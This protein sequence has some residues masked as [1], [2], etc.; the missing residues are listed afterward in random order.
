MS[1]ACLSAMCT[2]DDDIPL[3]SSS[4]I[5]WQDYDTYT[6]NSAMC[7]NPVIFNALA[8]DVC[9]PDTA[10]TSFKYKYPN[11]LSYMTPDCSGTAIK[12]AFSAISCQPFTNADG[13]IAKATTPSLFSAGSIEKYMSSRDALILNHAKNVVEKKERS[14]QTGDDDY[15]TPG[16]AS[17]LTYISSSS[18][19][20][21]KLSKG[22]VAGIIAGIIVFIILVVLALRLTG[23]IGD[24]PNISSRTESTAGSKDSGAVELRETTTS[25]NPMYNNKV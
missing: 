7:Y 15:V 2:N 16:V 17:S 3:P 6:Y 24:K 4:Y 13:T 20:S 8:N 10:S 14:L 5:T 9:V 25:Q 18:S 23:V 22:G 11:V 1:V 12:T 19:S 21:N